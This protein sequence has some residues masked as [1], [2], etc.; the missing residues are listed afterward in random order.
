MNYREARNQRNDLLTEIKGHWDCVTAALRYKQY[1]K[2]EALS[3]SRSY[4]DLAR[5]AHKVTKAAHLTWRINKI[6]ELEPEFRRASMRVNTYK[7]N[8]AS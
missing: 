3:K 2:L 8:R 7:I 1:Q 5:A 6:L 4:F